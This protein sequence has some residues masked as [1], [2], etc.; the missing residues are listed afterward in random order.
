LIQPLSGSNIFH[1]FLDKNL[2]GGVPHIVHSLPVA[3]LDKGISEMVNKGLAVI[4]SV[5][6]PVARIFFSTPLKTLAFFRK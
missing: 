5:N 2:A 6:H 4:T 3:E 1:D